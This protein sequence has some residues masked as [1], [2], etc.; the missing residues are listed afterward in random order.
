[1]LE[2]KRLRG[3]R[4]DSCKEGYQPMKIDEINRGMSGISIEGKITDISEPRRVQTR[5]GPRSVA[6]ATL[7]DDTGTIKLSLWEENITA[8]SIGDEVKISGA[9]VTEF[10]NQL[11]LNMPRSSKLEIIKQNRIEI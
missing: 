5:Y 9:Y 2:E 4:E 10:R 6:D 1:M 3:R 7:E 11:Q 8:V